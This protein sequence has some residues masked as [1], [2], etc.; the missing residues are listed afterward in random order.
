MT[1]KNWTDEECEYLY[2]RWGNSSLHAMSLHLGRQPTAIQQ[3][4]SKLGLGE[5]W[6]NGDNYIIKNEL[7]KS[8][9]LPHAMGYTV[10]KVWIEQ[11]GLPVHKKKYNK[12]IKNV[13]IIDEFWEWAEKHQG[14]LD[15][16]KFEPYALGPE[17][18]WVKAKRSRDYKLRRTYKTTSWTADEDNKLIFYLQ[19]QKYT[20]DELSK[21]LN[22]TCGAIQRRM[23][24]LSLTIRP[25]KANN[26]NKWTEEE[27]LILGEMIKSSCNYEEMSDAL[28]KSSKAIRGRVFREY[29]TERLDKV[30][31]YIGDGSFGDNKPDFPIKHKKIMNNDEKEIVDTNLSLICSLIIS[32]AKSKSNVDEEYKD[33]WQK[34]M[35]QHWDEITGCSLAFNTCDE[36][37]GF[38]RIQPQYCVRCGKTFYERKESKI[39]ANCRKQRIKQA[40]R[41]FAIL[42]S[43]RK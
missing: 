26:T 23:T 32:V 6:H 4:A 39:C 31:E 38:Q 18:E 29:L 3:K 43:R 42:N 20:V 21:K 9:G 14:I 17:P 16:S 34:D 19:Q 1:N 25:V 41:K 28:N 36:C 33:F 37:S 27:Y 12:E 13:I 2:E 8:L 15:F 30:R 24:G 22:R 35:C 7:C 40:Q 10:N 5:F 11:Y